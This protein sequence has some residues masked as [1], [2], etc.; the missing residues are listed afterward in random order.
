ME[1]TPNQYYTAASVWYKL[2]PFKKL[3][4]MQK[5]DSIKKYKYLSKRLK[6]YILYI[7]NN[8]LFNN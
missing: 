1:L 4:I 6:L 2:D 3:E 7:H 5:M 8:N